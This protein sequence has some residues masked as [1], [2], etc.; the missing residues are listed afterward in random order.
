[1]LLLATVKWP[2]WCAGWNT[3]L[4]IHDLATFLAGDG[5]YLGL[6]STSF[7][8]QVQIGPGEKH[9][10]FLTYPIPESPIPQACSSSTNVDK[11]LFVQGRYSVNVWWM[12]EWMVKYTIKLCP[13]GLIIQ[14]RAIHYNIHKLHI[15]LSTRN[16]ASTTPEL[17]FYFISV[18]LNFKI[19]TPF[20]FWKTFS[21]LNVL[22][23]CT[24]SAVDF[25]K[26][27]YR[28]NISHENLARVQYLSRCAVIANYVS[29]PRYFIKKKNVKHAIDILI[30]IT[31]GNYNIPGHIRFNKIRY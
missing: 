22:C 16:V 8:R 28:S 1:M 15:L 29:D 3:Q 20:P 5:A 19:Y 14:T 31:C 7:L 4:W 13:G 6:I 23:K 9:P 10:F 24:F 12:N 18:D 25:M 21:L 11:R 17:N 30:L 2:D 27:K 26:A